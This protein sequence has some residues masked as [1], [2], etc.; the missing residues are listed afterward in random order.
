M[1]I[2]SKEHFKFKEFVV[3]N[4]YPSLAS[5]IYLDEMDKYKIYILSVMLEHVRG[6]HD[7]IPI[8]IHSGKRSIVLNKAINGS[9]S[10]DHLFRDNSAAVDW[11]FVRDNEQHLMEAFVDLK[12]GFIGMIG[13]L[14]LY[15]DKNGSPIFIHLSL[16]TEKHCSEALIN[17]DGQ[18]HRLEN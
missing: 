4:D 18:F 14:I 10:S 3:S 8:N 15:C 1:T 5:I 12:L 17:M 6:Q 7:S 11:S 16:P 9:E 13:Q 2:R